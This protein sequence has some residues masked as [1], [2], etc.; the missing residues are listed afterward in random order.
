MG[1]T[2]IDAGVLIGFLDGNDAH[3][4][5]ARRQLNEALDR[6]D[7]LAI[8]ASA[9]A[10]ALVA[11]SGAGASAVQAVCDLVERIPLVVLDVDVGIALVAADVRA[12][13]GQ[14]L[15]LPD[16]LVVAT[17]IRLGAEVLVTTDRRWPSAADLGYDGNMIIL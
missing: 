8:P 5:G 3:H 11:P 6:R 16:A 12:R 9:F 1:L 15:R 17:A 13:W 7:P 14:K 2:L 4:G 10:E